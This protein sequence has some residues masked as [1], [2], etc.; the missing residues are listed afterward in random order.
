MP[1]LLR[2]FP[3]AR[4]CAEKQGLSDRQAKRFGLRSFGAFSLRGFTMVE[5]SS[6]GA[7]V[8]E[9]AAAPES[10][11]NG[12]A[13][14][15]MANRVAHY[16]DGQEAAESDAPEIGN[17]KSKA[18]RKAE[19]RA[20][21][22]DALTQTV[23]AAVQAET[24]TTALAIVAPVEWETERSAIDTALADGKLTIGDLAE[25]FAKME[26]RAESLNALRYGRLCYLAIVQVTTAPECNGMPKAQLEKRVEV[27]IFKETCHGSARRGSAQG[28][29]G[30]SVEGG[31]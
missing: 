7:T 15:I 4:G 12:H 3:L 13:E 24:D 6:S 31:T 2:M 23:G 1:L 22:V 9:A 8:D 21:R 19:R 29:S 25:R 30:Q 14:S 26:S 10:N 17:G 20:A 18:Q 11:G 5:Q 16:M 27:S 28:E